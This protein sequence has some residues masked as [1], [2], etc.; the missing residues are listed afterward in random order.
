MAEIMCR[1]TPQTAIELQ[2]GENCC[3]I[4]RES[5]RSSAAPHLNEVQVVGVQNPP[6]R[7]KLSLISRGFRIE[8]SV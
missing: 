8:P 1:G 5:G 3:A 4:N 6:A 2:H 7:P